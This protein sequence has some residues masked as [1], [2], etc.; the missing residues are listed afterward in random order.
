MLEET[1]RVLVV[2]DDTHLLAGIRDILEMYHY[3]VITAQNGQEGLEALQKSQRPDIIV[4]DIMMP[5]MDGFEFLQEVRKEQQWLTIPFIF[6]TAKGERNDILRGRKL[7]VDVYLTKP[8]DPD[9]LLVAVKA[10]LDRQRQLDEVRD[11]QVLDVKRNILTILNHE[12]RTPLTLV[13]AYS[14]MLKEY[15]REG[16]NEEELVSFLKGVSSGADRLRRL[17]ENFILL[18]EI[19]S[20]DAFGT[21]SWRKRTIAD[22]TDVIYFAHNQI[23]TPALTDYSCKM[24]ITPHPPILGDAEFLSV[25]VRELLSNS[26]KFSA[27]GT[28]IE[29][30]TSTSDGYVHIWVRDEG[31]GIPESELENIWK[32]FY[33]IDRAFNED[34]GAG[35][36]L[37]IAKG[38]VE[39]HEGVIEVES[40][41]DKGSTFTVKLP[42]AE[43]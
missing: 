37:T 11:G 22:L 12:F 41:V 23:F 17:V 7:G 27:P 21:F 13:V 42:I 34:Q 36:G 9:E 8:F 25:V 39:M 38:L 31:R 40:T 6:L 30:G 4:S 5:Y 24:S 43:E 29:I 19:E 3:D 33:Q 35:S 15:E 20:G 18:V 14:E 26:V 2:E 28:P 32:G 10:R 1:A 16:M